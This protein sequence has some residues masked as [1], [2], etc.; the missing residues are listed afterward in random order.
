MHHNQ[1]FYTMGI[2]VINI[3]GLEK[4][5]ITPDG[6]VYNTTTKRWIKPFITRLKY[7]SY[8]LTNSI[9]KKRLNYLAHRLV[10]YTYIGAPPNPKFEIDHIDENKGNNLYTNL[11]WISHSENVAKS[12]KLGTRGCWW[13]GKTRRSPNI[14][15][16]RKMADAKYKPINLYL[17]NQ[18]IKRFNSVQE[19]ATFFNKT[20]ITIYLIMKQS[21]QYKGYVLKWA[22]QH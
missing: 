14:E 8:P 15:T 3:E 6:Q 4:Y 2:Q 10:A 7:Y 5:A 21:G 20:R 18:L 16:R 13:L 11:Q 12:F 19:I 9:K 17:N 1:Y 22:K